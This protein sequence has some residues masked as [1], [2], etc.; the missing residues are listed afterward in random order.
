MLAALGWPTAELLNKPLSAA[1]G[2]PSLLTKAGESPSILNGGLGGVPPIYW[3]AVFALAIYVENKTLDTQL[4]IGKRD[5]NYLP[6]MLNFDPLGADSPTMRA[7]EITNGRIAMI[8]ITAFAI[9]EF[10][11]K[12]PVV[13]ETPV[14]FQP[15]W[16]TLG[17]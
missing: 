11:F 6:G 1:L 16:S 10:A 7:A 9:E 3:A 8:A 17:F 13:L 4:K 15:I 12:T 14:F 5:P 2:V